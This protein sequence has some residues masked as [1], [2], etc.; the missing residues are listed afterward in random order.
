MNYIK[1]Y[2]ITIPEERKVLSLAR[3]V[4]KRD[5]FYAEENEFF[6]NRYPSMRRFLA[7][8]DAEHAKN[9]SGFFWNRNLEREARRRAT[10]ELI[11]EVRE[12]QGRELEPRNIAYNLGMAFI[13]LAV[14]NLINIVGIYGGV[15]YVPGEYMYKANYKTKESRIV[16]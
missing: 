13:N 10:R 15:R 6:G 12:I 14:G 2:L 9:P 7:Q 11:V 4:A 3:K 1:N 16:G 5:S 8:M